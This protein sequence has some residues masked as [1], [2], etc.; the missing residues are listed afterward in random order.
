M[1]GAGMAGTV[2]LRSAAAKH[3]LDPADFSHAAFAGAGLG[4][5]LGKG[6]GQKRVDRHCRDHVAE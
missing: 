5:A 4:H 1:T 3:E 2:I 6:K